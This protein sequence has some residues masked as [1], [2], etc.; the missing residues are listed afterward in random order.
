MPTRTHGTV[1]S[2]ADS[3]LWPF[4]VGALAGAVGRT[5]IDGNG[6]DTVSIV[7]GLALVAYT[8]AVAARPP[9]AVDGRTA[10]VRVSLEF[11]FVAGS[12][13]ITG[14]WASPYVLFLI[15]TAMLAALSNGTLFSLGL[16]LVSVVAISARHATAVESDIAARDGL[17]WAGLLGLVGFTSGLARRTAVDAAQQQR[18]ALDRMGRLVEANSLLFA[19]QRVAQSMPASLDLDEVLDSTLERLRTLVDHDAVVVFLVDEQQ[20]EARPVR[21]RGTSV[22]EVIPLDR[23]PG[24][25]RLALASPK[26]VRLDVPG[27]EQSVAATATS[28]LYAAL[29]AR[30]T[31]VGLIAVERTLDP[32]LDQQAAEV[33]HGLSEPFGIAIDNARMFQRIRTRAADEERARI[34]RELHDQFGS[35]LALIGFELDRA[36][37]AS[38]DPAAVQPLLTDLRMQVSDVLREVRNTLFDLRTDVTEARDLAHTAAVFLD[39]VAQ[40]SGVSTESTIDDEARLPPTAEREV[41]QIAREAIINAERHARPERITVHGWVEDDRF[42]VT[43]VD[44][45]VGVDPTSARHDSF[46]MAGMHERARRLGAHLT[47]RSAAERGTEVRIEVPLGGLTI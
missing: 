33:I 14:S 15:P 18:D 35:S 10:L 7:V 44:D 32:A 47:V 20:R 21:S 23:L 4:R 46:G 12:I 39:H 31:I 28:G 5:V 3:P 24:G 43:V 40:R 42:V 22:T 34:A 37:A 26:T 45:G 30:G 9:T 41:W 17:L 27:T 2:L 1:N 16:S 11:A 29:R 8:V 36:I 38:P 25:L 19:L 6:L 13:V